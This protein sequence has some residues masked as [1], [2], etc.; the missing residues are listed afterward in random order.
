MSYIDDIEEND[1][2]I[3]KLGSAYN[4]IASRM[5]TVPNRKL[6]AIASI[7][8]AYGEVASRMA[9]ESDKRLS[10]IAGIGSAYGEVASRMAMESDK[11]LS[12]IAS[13]GSAYGGIAS[14]MATESDE[15]LSALASAYG[16][17]VSR[18][19]MESDERMSAIAGIGS[20]YD[21]ADEDYSE[22]L[23][24]LLEWYTTL[25]AYLQQLWSVITTDKAKDV[26]AVASFLMTT[27]GF[28]ITIQED[29][30]N[31]KEQT[32]EIHIHNYYNNVETEIKT[33]ENQND[34]YIKAKEVQ[35]NSIEDKWLSGGN[36]T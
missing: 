25:V 28:I 30:S 16:G 32:P 11:R 19:A 7:G 3:R 13:I 35:Q 27:I 15:R 26:M 12:A 24:T 10:A 36:R 4:G 21:E 34:L 6:S 5:A 20:V 29:V 14:R 17:I 31:K 8:S 1:R 33:E 18:M 23:E 2:R 22:H 9:M